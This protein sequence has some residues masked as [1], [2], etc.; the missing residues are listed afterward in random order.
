[1]GRSGATDEKRRATGSR[2]VKTAAALSI[3][4]HPATV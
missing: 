4:D 2:G 1:V 3:T